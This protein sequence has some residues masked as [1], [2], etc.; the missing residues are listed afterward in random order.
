LRFF[1]HCTICQSVYRK[2]FADAVIVKAG[3]VEVERMELI[4]FKKHRPP[5]NVNRGG[6]RSSP[7]ALVP[8]A[9][10]LRVPTCAWPTAAVI[11]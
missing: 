7:T 5:P 8:A 11:P 4:E 6:G 2:P 3:A 9:R 10:F 1:C